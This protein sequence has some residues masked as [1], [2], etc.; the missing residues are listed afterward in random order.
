MII[1]ARQQPY[2][3]IFDEEEYKKVNRENK[4]LLDDFIIE[5]KATKKKPST[6]AQYYNDGRIVLLYIK[7][8]LDNKSILELSKRDFRNFT[9]YYSEELG[10]SAARIN[11]L[12]SMVRTM[13]EYA[14]NEQ[15]YN[16][17][18]NNASKVKGL[19]KEAVREIEFLSNDIIMELYNYFMEN[20]RY[21]DATLLAL[22][23]E[24][25]A[26]KN[27]LAQVLKNS[28]TDDRNCTS[29]VVGK[30]RKVFPLIY[31]DYTKKAAKKYLEQRGEDDIPELF[32]NAD[33]KA[34]S[35]RNLYEWVVGW[36]KI[37]EQMTGEEQSFNVHSLRHSALENYS[38]GTH[39]HLIDNN[40]PSIPIEKLRLIA[41]HD[42][43]STTQGYLA[44]KDD[45]ELEDLFGISID[46]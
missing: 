14:S 9:L 26:R 24:S 8:K 32:V 13:L 30:R 5:C 18:I 44:P 42:N 27:E 39:Q 36:R 10:V 21:K 43:I 3:K 15:D 7:Q 22:A 6:I 2:N 31:F 37:V 34:A 28:V 23:Y 25:S 46:N 16:Y 35:P 29:P 33:G 17:L 41:R 4:D 19:P 12:M 20:E 1:L 40:M 45:K 11:R 38:N